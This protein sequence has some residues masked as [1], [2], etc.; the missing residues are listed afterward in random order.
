MQNEERINCLEAQVRILKR[1]VCLVCCFVLVGCTAK[2]CSKNPE[3]HIS[4]SYCPECGSMEQC[5]CKSS[6]YDRKTTGILA[7]GGEEKNVQNRDVAWYCNRCW[8]YIAP[9]IDYENL[10]AGMCPECYE[11]NNEAWGDS[12]G[13][14]GW[15]DSGGKEGTPW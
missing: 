1:I 4:L 8:K 11:I 5:F 7:I 15:G 14:E 2:S 10:N 6:F 12:G 13:N 3:I 9:K